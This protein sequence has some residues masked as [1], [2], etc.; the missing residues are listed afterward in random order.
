MATRTTLALVA[1]LAPL[2][3]A[4][5]Y[6]DR[7]DANGDGVVSLY[8]L[9]AAYYAD[10]EFN[11]Q[12]E[13]SFARYDRNGDGVISAE[14]RGTPPL[15]YGRRS[16]DAAVDDNQISE[17]DTGT[18]RGRRRPTSAPSTPAAPATQ[19]S[20]DRIAD[21]IRDIDFDQSG[22]ASMQELIV[23]GGGEPWFREADFHAA[24]ADDDGDLDA[25]ELAALVRSIERRQ[26]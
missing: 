21:W 2:A 18:L 26:R 15:E 20:G 8:E 7:A 23:S 5:E 11:R 9:R 16:G 3:M 25:A 1:F 6:V 24:D 17:L 13:Q 22:G 12:I 10:P 19:S 4:D 14:E